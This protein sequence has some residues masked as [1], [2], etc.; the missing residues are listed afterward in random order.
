M[1][2]DPVDVEKD[3]F[4]I[5]EMKKKILKQEISVYCKFKIGYSWKDNQLVRCL[6]WW[7]LPEHSIMI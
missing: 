5:L 7:M 1:K 6:Y 4:E 2:G 3:H